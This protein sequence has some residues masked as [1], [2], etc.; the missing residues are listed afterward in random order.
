[1]FVH[2]FAN[3]VVEELYNCHANQNER[4]AMQ[5]EVYSRYFV[6][7]AAEEEKEREEKEMG[8]GGKRGERE[9]ED[10]TMQIKSLQVRRILYQRMLFVLTAC[11]KTC[12]FS[13]S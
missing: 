6:M 9:G 10:R 8:Q 12:V 2:C 4:T 7:K 1:M 3:E 11:V 5:H 13:L